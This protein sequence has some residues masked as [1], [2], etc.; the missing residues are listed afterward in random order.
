MGFKSQDFNPNS[1]DV[2]TNESNFML[3]QDVSYYKDYA[4]KARFADESAS[5]KR[6]YRSFAIIPDI[7]AIDILTKYGINIHDPDTMKDPALMR[8]YKRIVLQ[9]YPQLLTSNVKSV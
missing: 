8:R 9:E 1:F 6:Q 5:S 4:E 2:N 3:S 7:V